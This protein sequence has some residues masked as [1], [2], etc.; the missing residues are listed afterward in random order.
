VYGTLPDGYGCCGHCANCA[1]FGLL[2]SEAL[3]D[4]E[5]RQRDAAALASGVTSAAI[6]GATVAAG[7]AS[8]GAAGAGTAA[9][10]MAVAAGTATVPV[11]GWIAAAVIASI[12]TT[13]ALVSAIKKRSIKKA[14]AI[15]VAK[16][17]GLPD[18]SGIENYVFRALQW[19]EFKVLRKLSQAEKRYARVDKRNIS[20]DKRVKNLSAKVDLLK[21]I[22][23]V[24]QQQ[25][26]DALRAQ[27][28]GRVVA[29]LPDLAVSTPQPSTTPSVP[30][31]L[32]VSLL[33]GSVGAAFL[34][35]Q[36]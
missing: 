34:W 24:Q 21:A 4:N 14:D 33:V 19:D 31:W 20:R 22:L 15:S 30:S 10:M 23:V 29:P 12:A 6:T 7:F 16:A 1:G 36:R 3:Y 9:T 13:I 5:T 17:L 32:L 27:M 8:G 26:M 28:T 35:T 18:P 11:A 25:R 2:G